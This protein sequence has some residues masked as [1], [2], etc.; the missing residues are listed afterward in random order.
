[1]WFVV[2]MQLEVNV[3][4]EA[5]VSFEVAKLAKSKGFV[6]S[7]NYFGYVDKFYEPNTGSIRSYGFHRTKNINDLIFAPTQGLLQKWM[8]EIHFISIELGMDYGPSW[9]VSVYI[10]DKD[11]VNKEE[12]YSEPIGLHNTYE[13]A[14]ETG[15]LKALKLIK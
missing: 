8:R 7:C 11:G 6:K 10:S 13:E 4:K 15:L 12:K 1:M 2:K 9:Y 3:M 14:L 5:I